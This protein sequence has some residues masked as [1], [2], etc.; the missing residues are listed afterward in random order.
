M[1]YL[2]LKLEKL[3]KHYNYSQ[4]YL[5]KVLDIDVVEYMGLENGRNMLNYSQMKKLSSLYHINVIEILR[6]DDNVTLYDVTNQDTDKINIE[7]FIPKKTLLSRIKERP[8]LTGIIV[9]AIVAITIGS[10]F[11]INSKN[12]P[13]IS[14]ADNTDRLSVS[15]TTVVYI[16]NVGA[17]KATGD[18]S[19]GQISSLP[20]EHAS[21]VCEG[22]SF[23]VILLDDGTVI[24]TGQVETYQ[25]EISKWKNIS[26]IAVGN[27]H[28]IAVDNIGKVYAV[29]DN[30]KGQCNIDDFSNIKNVYATNNGTICIDYDGEIYYTG[31]FVGTSKLKQYTNIKDVD[32][33]NDNLIVLKE[34]GTCDYIASYDSESYLPITTKWKDIIDVTCGDDYFAALKADGTVEI[35]ST[36]LNT[37]PVSNWT[38]I[39]AIDGCNDYLIG[40]D[41]SEIFGLGK[42][43]YHQFEQVDATLQELAPVKNIL[44]DY[45]TKEVKVSFSEVTNAVEYEVSL[46]IDASTSLTKKILAN[47]VA[48]FDVSDL[49]DNS[50]YEIKVKAIGDGINYNDSKVTTQEFLYLQEVTNSINEEKIKVRSDL[51]GTL[52]SYF[53][54]Y[55]YGI[56]VENIEAEVDDSKICDG[57]E[58]V[59]LEINGITPGN[60][61]SKAELAAHNVSYTYCKLDLEREDYASEN[62]EN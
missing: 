24:S 11:V 4:A 42:N 6:N 53:E 48:K 26:D 16:D 60:T 27:N 45:N 57:V 21:K 13:Y 59:V 31:E 18:N 61:Y 12:R 7:Y 51:S 49:I 41:G 55:L 17:V 10:I 40:F 15:S 52:T 9:G 28:I 29:G 3:R 39:I 47:E 54:E 8:I 34:D 5:A 44:I 62:L 32:T 36:S 22:S 50:I 19:N 46:V 14:Y 2:P 56:G 38:N 35:V 58:E 33:S 43:N 37:S 25:K 30:S 1:N 23:S 20:S